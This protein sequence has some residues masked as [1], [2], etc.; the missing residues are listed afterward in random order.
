MHKLRE[1]HKD[2]SQYQQQRAV[3]GR[4]ITDIEM[5]GTVRGAVEEFNLCTNLRENDALS[6]ECIRS[7]PSVAVS[8]QN[9]LHRLHVELG[10]V[11]DTQ[12]TAIVPPS[13]RPHIKCRKTIPHMDIYGFRA[14]DT[15]FGNLCAFEFLRYWTA[16][17]LEPPSRSDPKPPVQSG[18]TRG[19]S[20][21]VRRRSKVVR[22]R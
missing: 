3:S 19:D 12:V 15:P 1:L 9:W 21:S 2:K 10:E 5:N 22:R 13:K 4:M 20:S 7:F 11:S 16:E 17:A 8:A 18:Q 14:L 6:A